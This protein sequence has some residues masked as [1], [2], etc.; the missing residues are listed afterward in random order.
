[1]VTNHPPRVSG[2]DETM[3]WRLSVIRFD[4]VV[5]PERRG[6]KL[7]DRLKHDAEAILAWA[8]QGLA[9]YQANGL[10]PPNE[11]RL[12]TADYRRKSDHLGRFITECTTTAPSLR[13]DAAR[14]FEEWNAWAAAEGCEPIS[15]RAFTNAVTSRRTEAGHEIRAVRSN[16]KRWFYGVG[17]KASTD[18]ED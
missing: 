12:A 4:Q 11:V 7:P 16:G 1:M 18:D 14:L 13:V 3:W 15:R 8:V 2:D 10:E 9:D 5:P 6:A 17:L